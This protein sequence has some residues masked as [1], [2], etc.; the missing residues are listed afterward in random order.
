MHTHG[1]TRAHTRVRTYPAGQSLPKPRVQ[2]GGAGSRRA[3]AP[4]GRSSRGRLCASPAP[5]GRRQ[6]EAGAERS[7]GNVSPDR[8]FPSAL[9]A[10]LRAAGRWAAPPG[11][12][13]PRVPGSQGPARRS[14][15]SDSLWAPRWE[16]RQA[17]PSCGV[18]ARRAGKT[19]LWEQPRPWVRGRNLYSGP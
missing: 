9:T 6:K 11:S 4:G 7:P 3:R 15:F 5:C 10:G 8:P 14:L 19:A 17:R 16:E 13:S 12:Q 1:H 18:C 2:R